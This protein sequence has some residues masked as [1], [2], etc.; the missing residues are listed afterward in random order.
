MSLKQVGGQ[1][2]EVA[3]VL[4]VRYVRL[5]VES[6]KGALLTAQNLLQHR[7][8]HFGLLFEETRP[9]DLHQRVVEE[10]DPKNAAVFIEDKEKVLHDRAQ[11]RLHGCLV[12]GQ[13]QALACQLL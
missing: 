2:F 10:A 7:T 11:V 13:Q 1:N 3:N 6:P 4:Q 9:E 5:E 12:L 8:H